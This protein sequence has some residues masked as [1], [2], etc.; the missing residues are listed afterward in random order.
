MNNPK[1]K[2]GLTA[3]VISALLLAVIAVGKVSAAETADVITQKV[4]ELFAA[5]NNDA[6]PGAALVVIKDG[7]IIYKRG[8]GMADLESDV[9]IQP[10]TIFHVGSVSK[11]F[12]A[13]AV[14]LLVGEGKISLD[15]DVHKFVPE[16]YDFGKP[17]KI[18]HLLNHTSGLREQL[19]LLFMA[20]WRLEDVVTQEDL[21][22]VIWRQRELNFAPGAEY[23]YSNTNYTLLAL[24]VERVSGQS[25][26]Q[27]T[28]EKIFKPLGMTNTRFR[29]DYRTVT[30]NLALSYI[31]TS[32]GVKHMFL[33]GSYTGAAGLMTTA[34][35]LTLWDRNF[36]GHQVGGRETMQRMLANGTLNDGQKIVYASGLNVGNYRGL[37]TIEHSG[38]DAGYQADF[39]QFPE[40]RFSVIILSNSGGF[41]AVSTAWQIAELYLADEIKAAQEEAKTSTAGSSPV[42]IREITL[43]PKIIDGF[44]GDYKLSFGIPLKLSK[45]AG[46]LS[47][48]V[49]GQAAQPLSAVSPTEFSTYD[50]RLKI[51]FQPPQ[52]G[53]YIKL[54]VNLNGQQLDGEKIENLTLTDAAAKQYGGVYYSEE[55][56]AVYSVVFKD[57]K[58]LLLHRRGEEPLTVKHTDEFVSGFS[59]EARRW[60]GGEYVRLKFLR[61]R[62][63]TRVTGF[64][65]SMPGARNVRFIKSEKF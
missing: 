25:L 11:Q 3:F 17:L 26:A 15:D 39:L 33:A 22:R 52:N 4:D 10:S 65:L 44:I 64:L 38:E 23:L 43:A 47:V 61:D 18:R 20:G 49:R 46:K 48:A 1:T 41:D 37:K 28:E 62:P 40:Q 59:A 12:T 54:A 14:Q 35:D 31:P 34:E 21:L 27:Y 45:D 29:T 58:L 5:M 36:Y 32:Q 60:R 8:Y 9:K 16:L 56:N 2:S 6:S 51:K 7:K 50:G 63:T 53:K 30:K 57:G 24:I 19:Q 13:F 42:V 55:V